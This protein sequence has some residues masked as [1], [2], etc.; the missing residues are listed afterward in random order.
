MVLSSPMAPSSSAIASVANSSGSS[1]SS[2]LSRDSSLSHLRLSILKSRSLTSLMENERQRSSLE[3]LG[4]R[5]EWPSG[6]EPKQTS[7]S[8]KC[9]GLSGRSFL[10]IRGILVRAS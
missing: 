10:V 6:L 2:A 1:S 4:S 3:L 5:F 8:V 7:N 9:S